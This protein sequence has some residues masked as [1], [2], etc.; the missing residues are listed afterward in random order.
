MRLEVIDNS[1]ST[2]ES[3]L[4]MKMY[5]GAIAKA[6]IKAENRIKDEAIKNTV[7]G[8]SHNSISAR[9]IDL[10]FDVL[11]N[12]SLLASMEYGRKPGPI[13]P[14]ALERWA[15]HRL[16]SR[17]AAYAVANKIRKLGTEKYRRKE[18]KQLSRAFKLIQKDVE[19]ILTE[20]YDRIL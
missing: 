14:Q 13:N 12:E 3:L 20:M 1:M 2:Y 10:D 19:T 7:S 11:G 4:D 15:L 5:R 6:S 8:I 16:G 18:P 9:V 17:N